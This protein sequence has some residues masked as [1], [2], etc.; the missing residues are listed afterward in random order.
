[1][2]ASRF[3]CLTREHFKPELAKFFHLSQ[4]A[5]SGVS[6]C[7]CCCCCCFIIIFIKYNPQFAACWCQCIY[8]C[9]K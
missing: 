3:D 7:C 4:L 2:L 1:M 8:N 6:N 5:K 9:N